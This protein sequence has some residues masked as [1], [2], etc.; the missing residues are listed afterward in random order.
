[1]RVM[2]QTQ[3][4]GVVGWPVAQSKS[5]IMQNAALHALRL[6]FHYAPFAVPPDKLAR[7]VDGAMALG[8]RGLNITIPH[9]ERA[10]ALCEA[11]PLA[12][13]VGAVNTLVFEDDRVRGLNTDV[14]GFRMLMME[15]GVKPGTRALILGGG[16]AA[17]AVV[18]ALRS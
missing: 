14:H 12:L 15:A 18:A 1:M 6:P 2:G 11:D 8:I 13:E 9:K 3:V 7:A 10:L 17:R 4:L 16:G 5:P